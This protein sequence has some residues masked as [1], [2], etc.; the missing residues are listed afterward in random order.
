MDLRERIA[1]AVVGGETVRSVADRF[2]VSAATA[3]R[4]GQRGRAG[5]GLERPMEDADLA[6][7]WTDAAFAQKL[8]P[9]GQF[10]STYLAPLL[11]LPAVVSAGLVP[12]A[13]YRRSATWKSVRAQSLPREMQVAAAHVWQVHDRR[14]TPIPTLAPEPDA[15]TRVQARAQRLP[16]APVPAARSRLSCDAPSLLRPVRRRATPCAPEPGCLAPNGPP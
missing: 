11:L 1:A 4:L 9:A 3:V 12:W 6:G 14:S 13:V 8:T 16:L 2:G 15:G 7:I 10:A 5:V